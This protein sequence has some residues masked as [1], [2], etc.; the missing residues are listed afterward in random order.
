MAEKKRRPRRG[1]I[2]AGAGAVAAVG[3]MGTAM[4]LP[5]DGGNAAD[6]TQQTATSTAQV[7]KGDL[8]AAKT[9]SGELAHGDPVPLPGAG[10]GT[11]TWLPKAGDTI[12]RGEPLYKVDNRPVTALY[13][14]TPMYREL[15][16]GDKGPDVQQLNENLRALGHGAPTGD[17]YTSQTA[18][19]VRAWQK[20][21]GLDATGK[22]GKGVV[23][24]APGA[25]RIGELKARTG[26]P[27]TGDV[28]TYTGQ[29]RK[30]SAKL[31]LADQKLARKGDSVDVVLPNGK[32]VKGRITEVET[33]TSGSDGSGGQGSEGGG[34]GS[35]GGSGGGGDGQKKK[36]EIKV[37]VAI[38]DQKALGDLQNATV[39]VDFTSE[40]RK[41][42]FHVPVNALVARPGGGFG[43]EAVENGKTRTVPVELGMFTNGQVEVKGTDLRPGM[44]VVVP[45]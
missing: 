8:A 4:L 22:V 33:V 16:Q 11:V 3:A 34:G 6:S 1:R 14:D 43:V 44:Q 7:A 15:K 28:L 36:T 20:K 40:V 25:V 26:S 32:T 39:D 29:A 41:D 12:S 45:R 42:V 13:G 23:V 2:M 30:V 10:Q 35:G 18:S 21:L 5:G 38:E 17:T 9:V 24:F 27:A 37:T 31:P 19:A